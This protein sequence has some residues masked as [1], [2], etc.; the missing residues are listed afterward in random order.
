MKETT[1]D[2]RAM[3]KIN[4]A[5]RL[6]VSRP[7]LIGAALTHPSL[8]KASKTEDLEDGIDYQRLEFLGDRVLGL[9]IATYLFKKFS[10]ENEGELALRFAAL[11]S[12]DA[13]ASVANQAGLAEHIRVSHGVGSDKCIV[14][15]SI[16]ADSCEA[17]IG[18]IYID[19]GLS[20]ATD[21]VLREWA[22]LLDQQT[23]PPQDPITT[24]Q[25]WT[26]ARGLG[27]PIYEVIS[28]D[29]PSHAPIFEVAV[30]IDRVERVRGKGKS[31]KMATKAAAKDVLR[32]LRQ[33]D[34]HSG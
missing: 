9:V 11:V 31:K 24:L 1:T 6:G 12:A 26:Q 22:D 27:L 28:Q 16:L 14:A 2:L 32:R 7:E 20:K 34:E 25:I 3:E 18:A 8:G 30:L 5:L 15:A 33:N 23:E 4:V 13:L 29:G 19:G 10:D 17:L 21:F